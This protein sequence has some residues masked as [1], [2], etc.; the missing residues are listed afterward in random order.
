MHVREQYLNWA[1]KNPLKRILIFLK[2]KYFLILINANNFLFGFRQAL[3]RCSSNFN[4]LS[5]VIPMSLTVRFSHILLLPILV[6]KCSNLFPEIKRTTEQKN[7]FVF[8][9]CSLVQL[10]K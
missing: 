8:N 6:H 10:K 4:S 2:S 7:S 9:R 1:S 3:L 5:V